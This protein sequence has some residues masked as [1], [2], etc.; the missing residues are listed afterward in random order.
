[1]QCSSI[2]VRR[3]SPNLS[4]VGIN[5]PENQEA[6]KLKELKNPKRIAG[7]NLE[8]IKIEEQEIEKEIIASLTNKLSI[9]YYYTNHIFKKML[10][11]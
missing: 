5:E 8:R 1:M 11:N 4:G 3:N 2:S 9:I 7:E 6:E 10:N